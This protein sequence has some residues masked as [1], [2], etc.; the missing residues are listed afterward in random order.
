M[1]CLTGG[2]SSIGAIVGGVI[3]GFIAG[4]VIS[5]GIAAIVIAI[6]TKCRKKDED[7]EPHP[8]TNKFPG[9]SSTTTAEPYYTQQQNQ[10]DD[11]GYEFLPVFNKGSE[12][13]D[14][15]DAEYDVPQLALTGLPAAHAV[16][17]SEYEVMDPVEEKTL[18]AGR[19]GKGDSSKRQKAPALP[20]QKLPKPTFIN[21]DK[22]VDKGPSKAPLA[23]GGKKK[24]SAS[25]TGE[26]ATQSTANLKRKYQTE[27]QQGAV[28]KGSP[29]QH[30]AVGQPEEVG[31]FRAMREKLAANM[32][33][34]TVEGQSAAQQQ[35]GRKK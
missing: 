23:P 30:G 22:T 1:E 25:N 28:G 10:S 20:K 19:G 27:G 4:T 17:N 34:A 35:D 18:G 13:K 24:V 9:T 3:G 2:S 21:E 16:V 7:M 32:G 5:L 26:R 6:V 33:G 31:G 12:V 11:P 8:K 15:P 14:D 29:P